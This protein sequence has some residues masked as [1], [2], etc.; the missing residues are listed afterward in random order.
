MAK[1]DKPVFYYDDEL[2]N[3]FAGTNISQKEVDEKFRFIHTNPLWKA[4]S[5]VLYYIIA[6]PLVW[7]YERV[8]LGVRFVNRKAVK[9][10][11]DHYFMYGNHTGFF[12]AFT[13]NLISL[14]K[15][16]RII[17]GPDTVSIPC[18]CNI[19]QMMGAI[20]LPTKLSAMRR[21]YEAVEHY[22]KSSNITIFP[23]AHIWPY[24]TGVRPFTAA[25]FAY[26]V[27]MQAPVVAFFVA[28]TKP[29]GLFVFLK[30]A[31]ITVY[32]SDPIY[33]A[34]GLARHEMQKDLRDKV[35]SFMLEKSKLSD[36]E[37]IRYVKR[38]DAK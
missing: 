12:D 18:I 35:Y 5:F 33:P 3:D 29:T 20:P 2:N 27:Q 31:D 7:F 24:Y 38:S 17:V 25:S 37:V 32:V 21:F 9:K 22:H 14:P 36:Y 1:K 8:L 15:R 13:P 16:N 23:E 34:A 6:W 19:V 10:C 11:D 30:K 28:Y 26:P 4:C